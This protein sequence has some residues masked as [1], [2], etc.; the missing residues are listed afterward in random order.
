MSDTSPSKKPLVLHSKTEIFSPPHAYLDG[1]QVFFTL[2]RGWAATD[3]PPNETDFPKGWWVKNWNST[4]LFWE[5]SRQG[6]TFEFDLVLEG[7]GRNPKYRCWRPVDI[8]GHHGLNGYRDL[9]SVDDKDHHHYFFVLTIP[10]HISPKPRMELCCGV[11]YL[12]KHHAVLFPLMNAL[13][14]SCQIK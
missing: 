8:K 11:R 14:R 10:A 9:E 5:V 3:T 1:K 12:K 2:P 7:L 6:V 4:G 13:V